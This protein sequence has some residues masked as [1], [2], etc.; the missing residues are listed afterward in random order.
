MAPPKGAE[1]IIWPPPNRS[2]PTVKKS[3]LSLNIANSGNEHENSRSFYTFVTSKRKI[4]RLR[5][6]RAGS[7]CLLTIYLWITNSTGKSRGGEPQGKAPPQAKNDP[8]G[9]LN[10][11]SSEARPELRISR[12]RSGTARTDGQAK[13]RHGQNYARSGPTM[14]D[15][16]QPGRDSDHHYLKPGLDRARSKPDPT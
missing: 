3:F 2:R 16:V 12:G 6:R 11:G 15:R 5:R 9:S 1:S 10:R 8:S 14:L 13:V 7:K 4:S